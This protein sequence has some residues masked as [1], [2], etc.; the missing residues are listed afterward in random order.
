M[1]LKRERCKK[2]RDAIFYRDNFGN[3]GREDPST[4]QKNG[5]NLIWPCH[6]CSIPLSAVINVSAF[7]VLDFHT[8]TIVQLMHRIHRSAFFAPNSEQSEKKRR[9]FRQSLGTF[10][11]CHLNGVRYPFPSKAAQEVLTNEEGKKR[12]EKCV[13]LVPK[14]WK[15]LRHLGSIFSFSLFLV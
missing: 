1:C 14:S 15:C 12:G 6:N 7:F 8:C 2:I 5:N 9:A 4:A 10:F 13:W 3:S 11:S